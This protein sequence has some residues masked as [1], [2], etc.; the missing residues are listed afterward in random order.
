MKHVNVVTSTGT[1]MQD[2][3]FV[4]VWVTLIAAHTKHVLKHP[5][6]LGWWQCVKCPMELQGNPLAICKYA[7][8]TKQDAWLIE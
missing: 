2:T 8:T 5:A 1:I 7:A 6:T 3:M 4:T